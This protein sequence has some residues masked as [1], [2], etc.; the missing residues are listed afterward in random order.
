MSTYPLK[1]CPPNILEHNSEAVYL[2]MI[3]IFDIDD[4]CLHKRGTF[5]FIH[6]NFGLEGDGCCRA[7]PICTPKCLVPCADKLIILQQIHIGVQVSHA[8]WL[9]L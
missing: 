7:E 4:A 1:S 6:I 9:L 3:G 5:F 2:K 8:N